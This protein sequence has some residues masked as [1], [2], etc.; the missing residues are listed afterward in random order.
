M[1]HQYVRK[2]SF[3]LLF[4]RIFKEICLVGA[5]PT[6][7]IT[8]PLYC[9]ISVYKLSE[10]G[11][12][13]HVFFLFGSLRWKCKSYTIIYKFHLFIMFINF[14]LARITVVPN[15]KLYGKTFSESTLK[16]C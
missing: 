1:L 3:K 16:I 13:E 9:I 2:V 12:L 11:L 5:F 7:L 4:T 14:F 15:K 10:D 8:G 6:K